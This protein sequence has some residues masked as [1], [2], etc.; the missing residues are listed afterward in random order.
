MI[1]RYTGCY[2]GT[3]GDIQVHRVTGTQSVIQ[4]YTSMTYCNI[5]VS[6]YLF[7]HVYKMLCS[8]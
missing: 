6:K 4:A 7:L 8:K 2:S 1:F 3:Q 5:Y